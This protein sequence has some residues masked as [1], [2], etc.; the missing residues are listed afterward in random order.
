MRNQRRAQYFNL[1]ES[2]SISVF[3]SGK[4]PH[5]SAD[6]YYHFSVNKN[7]WYLTGIDQEN[8]ILVLAKSE[9]TTESF[10]FIQKSDPLEALW[11]GETLSF[12]KAAEISGIK[13]ENV[14]DI[15][16]F[17]KFLSPLLTQSRRALFG[18][19]KHAYFDIERLRYDDEPLHGEKSANAFAR[20]YPHININN[21]Q[22]VLA[23]LR[24]AKDSEEVEATKGAIKISREANLHLLDSLKHVKYE[25]ELEAEFNYVLNKHQTTP[26]FGSIVA[27]GKNATILHYENNNMLLNQGDLVLLDLGVRYNHYA[28]DITRTYPVN[29]KYT[30]RQKA[31]YQAVLN[32]NKAIINWVKAGITQQAYNEKGKEL[33][34]I[35][36]KKLGLIKNDEEISKYYY[37]GLG[38]A[39][40][41]DVHDVGDP[42]VSF[43]VGQILTVEPGLYIAEESIGVRIE[44]NVLLTKDGCINLS[45]SIIK[46]VK[47]IE[48]YLAKA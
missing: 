45:E 12:E 18:T 17:D 25:Y 28:S 24:S 13:L 37:H 19:I 9:L 8:A 5:L 40:G 2:Q 4:A 46:E 11:V 10:L 14:R 20:K 21:S 35:E 38:H 31:V 30:D 7:F 34:T 44:D 6:A 42:Q 1:I 26:S 15:E 43:K 32:V 29:G 16:T 41:L 27:G 33:L 36:A 39:L 48:T 47:D 23:S 3:Y 22:P